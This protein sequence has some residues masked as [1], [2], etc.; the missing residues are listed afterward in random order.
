MTVTLISL[1]HACVSKISLRSSFGWF[2]IELTGGHCPLGY[3]DRLWFP[4]DS[5]PM[6]LAA[7]DLMPWAQT[8]CFIGLMSNQLQKGSEFYSLMW[9]SS[10]LTLYLMVFF[11]S[12]FMPF[13]W[14]MA[15][16]CCWL[17]F[18]FLFTG[19]QVYRFYWHNIQHSCFHNYAITYVNRCRVN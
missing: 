8:R 1:L 14:G 17:Y 15:I 19:L 12:W 9:L 10:C 6:S 16:F 13:V 5:R 2:H 7:V 4:W 18:P 3:T 11:A